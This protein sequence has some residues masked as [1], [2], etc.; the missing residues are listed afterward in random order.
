MILNDLNWVVNRLLKMSIQ[1]VIYRIEHSIK[2]WFDKVKFR[3]SFDYGRATQSEINLN[4]IFAILNIDIKILRNSFSLELKKILKEANSIVNNKF[5]VFGIDVC[6]KGKINWHLDPKT[7]KQ[8]PYK[9]YK[10]ID[11]RNGFTYGGP[12]FIWEINRF[13]FLPTLGLSYFLTNKKKYGDK[14]FEIIEDWLDKNPYLYGVNWVSNIELSIRTLNLLWA[15]SLLKGYNFDIKHKKLINKFIYLHAAQIY[16]YPSKYSSCNNHAL[17]E[18]LA[19]FACGVY[20]NNLKNSR[21]WF[22]YGKKVLEREVVHQ[23][24]ADGGSAEISTTY[25]SFVYDLFLLF[26][27]ICDKEKISYSESINE[28]LRSSTKFIFNLMDKKGNIPNIGDQDSAIVVNFGLDNWGNFKSILNTG[29]ILFNYSELKKVESLDLK[30][31]LLFGE[32]GLAKFNEIESFSDK[33]ENIFFK[34]SGIY[35]IKGVS[36]TK[37]ILFCGNCSPMG[38]HPLYAHGHLDALSFTLS[39]DGYEIFI[40]PGTYLYHSGDKW[41]RYFRSTIAHNTV[42]INEVDFS[43]QIADFMYGKPYKIKYN[44]FYSDEN[45]TKWIAEHNAYNNKLVKGFHERIFLYKK[46]IGEF[47]ITDTVFSKLLEY[48]VEIFFH[49]DPKCKVKIKN[50]SIYISRNNTMVVL[51]I[52]KKLEIYN[53]YGSFKPLLGWYSKNF[54]E[55]EKTHTLV[56]SGTFEGKKEI[57]TRGVIK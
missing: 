7:K 41:R 56:C 30:N 6:F 55:I 22:K 5:N 46:R 51:D 17:A 43:E 15:V 25:L 50:R 35:V 18:A 19:L 13:Y 39:I 37:E 20:F 9:F 10:D 33:P 4:K 16:K 40:D 38:M 49:L 27:V 54:N 12:K 34:N 24:L 3:H 28:R 53:Y 52:D 21:K 1:E 8:W 57:V 31:Y 32:D 45:N 14:I 23:I 36:K 11:I 26:K 44:K 29:S 47:Q 48:K 2:K 42:R